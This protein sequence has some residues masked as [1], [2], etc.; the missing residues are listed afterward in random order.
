MF[1]HWG[2]KVVGIATAAA[3]AL[4]ATGATLSNRQSDAD[5]TFR[6]QGP[7][8]YEQT[9]ATH[10]AACS[11]QGFERMEGVV[12]CVGHDLT[13]LHCTAQGTAQRR[14]EV[15]THNGAASFARTDTGAYQG[16]LI[17]DYGYRDQRSGAASYETF[18]LSLAANVPIQYQERTAAGSR[19]GT[20]TLQVGAT[21]DREL[22][23]HEAQRV[24]FRQVQP[25]SEPGPAGCARDGDGFN[26]STTVTVRLLPTD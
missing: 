13:S 9:F 26:G 2:L 12:T 23:H 21:T 7:F 4:L 19:S 16:P 5:L 18:D 6:W 11:L 10:A 1:S 24:E 15:D 14:F 22:F 17:V 8:H 3:A 25:I 20:Y